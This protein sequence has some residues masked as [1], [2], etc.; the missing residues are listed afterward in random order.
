MSDSI[1]SGLIN[2]V[3][4][5]DGASLL[6]DIISYYGINHVFGVV[7]VPIVEIGLA[8]QS[9]NIV[10]KNKGNNNNIVNFYGFRNE[11]SGSYA[12]SISG[13]LQQYPSICLTVP[14][15]GI[16]HAL[17]GVANSYINCWPMI[18]ISGG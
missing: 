12:C 3:N 7:G 4:E 14:G 17:A 6:A 5:L 13:Y 9:L 18:L 2:N 1:V 16:I 8:I 11:Q 15:P 10:N